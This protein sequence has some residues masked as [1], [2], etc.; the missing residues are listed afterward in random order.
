MIILSA[1]DYHYWKCDAAAE[2]QAARKA[3]AEEAKSSAYSNED[4]NPAKSAPAAGAPVQATPAEESA[5]AA[6]TAAPESQHEQQPP[7]PQHSEPAAENAK[8]DA[9]G[10]PPDAE[11][12]NKKAPSF[13]VLYTQERSELEK[14]VSPI[15]PVLHSNCF[16]DL[17]YLTS[18]FTSV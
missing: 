13:K 7:P 16:P 12:P 5:A 10:K 8:D 15:R 1:S 3:A 17:Q 4:S 14:E 2:R 18:L 9:K 6:A 11:S